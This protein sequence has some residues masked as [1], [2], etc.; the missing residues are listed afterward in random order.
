MGKIN[1]NQLNQIRFRGKDIIDIRLGKAPIK[2]DGE[3][4]L[5]ICGGTACHASNSEQVRDALKREVETRGLSN[6]CKV[7]ETGN[8]AFATLAP[9]M[10]VYP[11]GVYYVH[12]TPDDVHDIVSQHLIDGKPVERLFYRDMSSGKPIPRMMDIPYFSNQRM[13]TLR[14]LTLIDPEVIDDAIA[15]DAYQGAAKALLDM[16][17]EEIIN[18]MKIS[19][20]RGRGG[21]GFPTGMK[22]EFASKSAGDV[23]YILCNA[24]EGDPGAFMDRSVL[25]ADPHAVLEGMIIAAKAINAHQGYIYCRAEYPL[26]IKRLGIAI[27]QA[28]QYGL[29]GTNILGSGFDFDLEIYQGAGAF[30][31]GEETA[32]MTSIEGKRGMPRPR[33]PFPAQEGLWKKPTVLN[34]VETLA[35]VAQIILNGGEWY[36]SVGTDSSK[37]TKVFALSGKV[38]N[39]GLVEVPMGMPLKDIVYNIG[40][41]IPNAKRF[42]G[43]QLGGPS[44]GCIPS[45]LLDTV[46]DYEAITSTGAIMGSGGMVVMDEDNCMVDIARFFMEFC[47]EESCGKCT[48]GREGT[49]RMLEILTSITKG[50]GELSDIDTLEELALMVKDSA[51]CGLGQT[52]PNPVL[53]TLRYFRHEYEDHILEHHCE[54]G[55]C[56]DLFKAR[57]INACPLGQE[58]PGY[59]SL[60]EEERFEEAIR[61]IRQTNPMPGTLGRVCSHPC[62]DACV[63]GQTDAPINI[64]KIKRYAA[65][66]ARERGVVVEFKKAKK[67]SEKIAVIGGGPSGLG[68]AY[69]LSLM[70][71]NVTIFE[72]LPKLGGMLRYGIPAYRLPRDILDEE[73]NYIIDTG[74]IVRTGVRVG[75]E[76]SMEDVQKDFDAIFLGIGAHRSQIM[77][78]PGED[79]D[80]VYGGAEF[81]RQVELGNTPN[82]GKKV[83]VIGGG[84]TAIDVA[85]TCRRMGADVT[86]LY[87]RE[88]KDMPASAE[89]IEDG[90]DEGIKLRTF[91]MPGSINKNNGRLNITLH[92]CR[93]GEFDRDGRRTPVP[94]PDAVVREE[95]DTIFAAIGQVSDTSFISGLDLKRGW[96]EIDRLTLKT[97]L[98]N[99]YAGG[100]AVTGPALAVE[101][102]AAGKRAAISIDRDLSAKKGRKPYEEQYDKIFIT[103]R[104]PGDIIKQDMASAPKISAEERIKDFRE[105]EHG[106]DIKSVKG[107]CARCL[108]CDVK[109]D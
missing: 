68:A 3:K 42:K 100:D 94:L 49:K 26:A 15:R 36:A 102:L 18:Q 86:I 30:V 77:G 75:R 51:L 92:K 108:R 46:T 23:K 1:R 62:M 44:G 63:R 6:R 5:M 14:N 2:A 67:N 87:R 21:A 103:M 27:G 56:S 48:P 16:T 82:I 25:E 35:N 43:V 9:V 17:A 83:A 93:P 107:E 109:I 13:V 45:E 34:N 105:V 33:P 10:V 41:G 12:L 24:D 95:Y 96:I 20:L 54:A 61:L 81:L 91:M 70:G 72:E 52:A 99:I 53:S 71:Y 73:I 104:A 29:L 97:N 60:V 38:N 32:L 11:E 106:F 40:G 50:R 58:V 57:C 76:I 65:D 84:N 19:G 89:E 66:M 59:I 22:W 55:V 90:I 39:S 37:G 64:P 47:Q 79:M 101:A 69:Y 7:I 98:D 74:I 88:Q 78:I 80:G 85:R 31:C 28:R 8:D 4:H